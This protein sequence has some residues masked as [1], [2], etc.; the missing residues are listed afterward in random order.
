MSAPATAQDRGTATATAPVHG[1]TVLYDAECALCRHVRD[2]LAG[3]PKLVPVRLV[4]AA[5]AEARERFPGLDPADTLE[6]VT[7]V[8]DAGQVYRGARAWIV[9]LWA[10]REHRPLAHKL[11]TPTGMRFARGA[12]LAAA[13]Y[14]VRQWG[15]RE[16]YRR[17]DGWRYDPATG[18]VHSSPSCSDGSC[19]TG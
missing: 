11:S 6:Q 8:G 9:V 1:L 4:A 5:S 2:W 19:P 17:A 7:V 15:G 16:T 12:V 14:R 3:Q 10:L 13:K 18:W